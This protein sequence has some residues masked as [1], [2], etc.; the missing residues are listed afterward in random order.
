LA[1]T[2]LVR[3]SASK[4]QQRRVTLYRTQEPIERASQTLKRFAMDDEKATQFLLR[5]RP[6]S[7]KLLEAG[8]GV[9]APH[10]LSMDPSRTPLLQR[11]APKRAL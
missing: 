6:G 11:P 1:L 5:Q 3:A 8:A 7:S 10:A 4:T 2:R 9:K